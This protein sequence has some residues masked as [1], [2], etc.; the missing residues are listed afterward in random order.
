MN[1]VTNAIVKVI[2]ITKE[3][4]KSSSQKKEHNKVIS[5]LE[6]ALVWSKQLEPMVHEDIVKN[7]AQGCFCIA[8]AIDRSCPIHG[9]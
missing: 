3:R 2:T 6:D 5:K 1:D 4:A 8:G 9:N 7:V